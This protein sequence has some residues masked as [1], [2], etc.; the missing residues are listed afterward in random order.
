MASEHAQLI[1][2]WEIQSKDCRQLENSLLGSRNW[3]KCFPGE[4]RGHIL[5]SCP[6]EWLK[7]RLCLWP[8]GSHQAQSS[9]IREATD[10]K[11][12]LPLTRARELA[13]TNKILNGPRGLKQEKRIEF[14]PP[15][16]TH[17][18]LSLVLLSFKIVK[19]CKSFCFFNSCL[20][21]FCGFCA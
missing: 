18:Y 3:M 2:W 13:P 4:S 7:Q 12:S 6:R 15:H 10:D 14:I 17:S 21:V 8:M 20:L 19:F 11:I 16:P 1:I 5:K 9:I